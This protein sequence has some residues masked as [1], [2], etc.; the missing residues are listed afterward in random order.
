MCKFCKHGY[1]VN[2]EGKCQ[3]IT[4]EHCA[5]VNTEGK[6][7]MCDDEILITADGICDKDNEC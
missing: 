7:I 3:E 1:F 2:K 4:I 6:C 5:E